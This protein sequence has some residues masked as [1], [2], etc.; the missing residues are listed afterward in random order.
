MKFDAKKLEL[1]NALQNFHQA[2]DKLATAWIESGE[3]LSHKYPF[4][5]SFD[6]HA[7]DAWVKSSVAL[8]EAQDSEFQGLDGRVYKTKFVYSVKEANDFVAVRPE[9][10]VLAEIESGI[11]L[12]LLSDEGTVPPSRAAKYLKE[13]YGLEPGDMD[14][15]PSDTIEDVERWAKK[16][17]LT[18]IG[19][20]TVQKAA[21]FMKRFGAKPIIQVSPG[22]ILV[23]GIPTAPNFDDFCVYCSLKGLRTADFQN[24]PFEKQI[25]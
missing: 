5:G 20:M 21:Q 25:V 10:G 3:D 14:L 4:E 15:K 7:V 17:G 19:Q 13:V 24:W 22:Q 6:E 11:H 12:A 8:L 16:C 1:I 23:D 2:F 18:P 9:Y